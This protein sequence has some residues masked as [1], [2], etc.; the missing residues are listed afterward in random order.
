MTTYDAMLD[1]MA[2]ITTT[3]RGMSTIEMGD[4]LLSLSTVLDRYND[5]DFAYGLAELLR[6]V[7]RNLTSQRAPI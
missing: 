1:R 4:A 5:D 3:V 6:A 2:S 7:G